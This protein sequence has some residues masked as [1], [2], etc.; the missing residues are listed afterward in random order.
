MDTEPDLK[1]LLVA[2][3][4]RL[5]ADLQKVEQMLRLVDDGTGLPI[6]EMRVHRDGNTSKV[7][8]IITILRDHPNIEPK[9][10]AHWMEQGG[11]DTSNNIV[12]TY[13]HR[14]KKQGRVV[15]KGDRGVRRY[16]L[17]PPPK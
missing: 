15:A 9:E 5:V 8:A 2:R 14:L 11:Y 4:N 10:I 3:R 17:A 12:H 13:L 6:G 16:S 1:G 7:N